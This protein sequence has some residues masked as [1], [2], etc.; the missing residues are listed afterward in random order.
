[1]AG[2]RKARKGAKANRR[3]VR[4]PGRALVTGRTHRRLTLRLETQ[5]SPGYQ[6][7]PDRPPRSPVACP[8]PSCSATTAAGSAR[9]PSSCTASPPN[10]PS[11]T[12]ARRSPPPVWSSR[13]ACATER[14]ARYWTDTA[15]VHGHGRPPRRLPARPA[16]RR[17]RSPEETHA[18]PRHPRPDLRAA[19]LRPDQPR[20]TRTC[21]LLRHHLTP[22]A[23]GP[24]DRLVDAHSQRLP[25]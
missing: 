18:R 17:T 13:K 8:G 1:M 23:C 25:E 16:R 7:R 15:R 14:H 21:R 19:H 9:P 3:L 2:S 10:T 24:V 20:A 5:P 6:L 11:A 12:P 22:V 4:S